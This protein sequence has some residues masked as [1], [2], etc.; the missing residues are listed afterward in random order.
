MINR[1]EVRKH[2]VETLQGADLGIQVVYDHV[3]KDPK[4]QSPILTVESGP[5]IYPTGTDETLEVA[6]GLILGI[7]VRRDNAS[8]AEDL[9]D[10]LSSAV[11]GTIDDTYNA[12]FSQP[13]AL[14]YEMLDGIEYRIE[15]LP[16]AID[17]EE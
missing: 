17:W 16:V 6:V 11:A 9:L 12:R 1:K 10:D 7:W 15:F 13:S 8:S 4:G 2:V 14:D 5:V 3:P